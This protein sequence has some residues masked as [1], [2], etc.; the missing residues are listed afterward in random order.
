MHS[1]MVYNMSKDLNFETLV[2]LRD[3]I[4]EQIQQKNHNN[5]AVNDEEAQ[6]TT[7]PHNVEHSDIKLFF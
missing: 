4:I 2:P 3:A 5:H 7:I 6:A 1:L